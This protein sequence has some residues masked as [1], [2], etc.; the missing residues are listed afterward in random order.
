MTCER[1]GNIY[2]YADINIDTQRNER[3]KGRKNNTR[4]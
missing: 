3:G 2:I 4:S 1:E